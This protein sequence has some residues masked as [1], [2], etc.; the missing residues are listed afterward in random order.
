VHGLSDAGDGEHGSGKRRERKDAAAG[1][2]LALGCLV[3]DGTPAGGHRG[4]GGQDDLARGRLWGGQRR[5]AGR[6]GE[7]EEF[8]AVVGNSE[9]PVPVGVADVETARMPDVLGEVGA[10]GVDNGCA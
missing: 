2:A 9:R 1:G 7:F 8:S 4:T 6:G 10:G 5:G 3:A